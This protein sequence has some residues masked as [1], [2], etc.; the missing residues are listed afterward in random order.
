MSFSGGAAASAAAAVYASATAEASTYCGLAL[1]PGSPPD[2]ATHLHKVY[3]DAPAAGPGAA[4]FSLYVGDIQASLDRA[5]LAALGVTHVINC[6]P[7]SCGRTPADW[8]PFPDAFTYGFVH[9]NDSFWAGNMSAGDVAAQDP[10]SQ[11]HA[12]M[13]LLRECRAAGGSALVHCHWCVCAAAL[14]SSAARQRA[15]S[16]A[17]PPPF[18]P[19]FPCATRCAGASTGQ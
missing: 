16:R 17:R 1:P 10:S 3:A 8:A 9:S 11:W 13:L 18:S 4:A 5:Q 12:V 2:S 6:C 19:L 15:P 7:A 14:G